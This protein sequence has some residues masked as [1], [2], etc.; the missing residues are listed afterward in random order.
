MITSCQNDSDD[1]TDTA[2]LTSSGTEDPPPTPSP[3][4]EPNPQPDMPLPIGI[5]GATG[6]K[7]VVKNTF[8]EIQFPCSTGRVNGKIRPN[9]NGQFNRRG[10]IRFFSNESGENETYPA[11]FSGISTPDKSIIA[12]KITSDDPRVDGGSQ[13]K[14]YILKSNYEP[15]GWVCAY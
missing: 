14:D 11:T 15:P 12:L 3:I 8:V 10:T 2:P 1:P 4:P 9:E 5:W 7:M 13:S 6:L